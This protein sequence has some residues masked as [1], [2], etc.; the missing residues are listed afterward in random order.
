MEVLRP[1]VRQAERDAGH[2][3]GLTTD[4]RARL[5]QLEKENV[6]LKHANFRRMQRTGMQRTAV[7]ID[8]VGQTFFQRLERRDLRAGHREPKIP[9]EHRLSSTVDD[10]GELSLVPTRVFFV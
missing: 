6:E 9:F 7:L 2:R 4:E 10:A 8:P 1:W 3:A 5:K